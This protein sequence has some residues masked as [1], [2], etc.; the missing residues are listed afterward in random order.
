MKQ[1][2]CGLPTGIRKD[3][4][5]MIISGTADGVGGY[6]K[7][8]KKLYN[9]YVKFG[10]TPDLRLIEGARHELVNETDK[11]EIYRTVRDFVLSIH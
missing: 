1:K 8:V 2:K 10:L 6:G 5:L 11:Q 9:R 3:L 4:P 7:L